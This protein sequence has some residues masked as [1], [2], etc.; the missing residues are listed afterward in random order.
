VRHEN[1]LWLDLPLA[2]WKA[3]LDG[4]AGVSLH[5]VRYNSGRLGV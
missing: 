1:K 4:M 5:V 3:Y 2:L